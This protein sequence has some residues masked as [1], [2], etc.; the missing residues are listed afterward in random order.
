[1]ERCLRVWII[2]GFKDYVK[3]FGFIFGLL[4]GF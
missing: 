4:M 1:M 2:E 3:G